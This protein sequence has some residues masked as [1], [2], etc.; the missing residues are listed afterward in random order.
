MTAVRSALGADFPL[1][2]DANMGYGLDVALAAAAAF[3][4]LGIGWLEEPLFMEDVAGHAQLK[5]RSGVPR[6]RR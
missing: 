3:E 5:A 6:G 4:K 1:M 2:T